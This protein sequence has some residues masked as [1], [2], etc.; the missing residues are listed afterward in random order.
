MYCTFNRGKPDGCRQRNSKISSRT[1]GC[2]PPH[3]AS[4]FVLLFRIAAHTAIRPPD[5]VSR[6]P[7]VRADGR[8]MVLLRRVSLSVAQAL[9]SQ[10]TNMRKGLEH[11]IR[12]ATEADGRASAAAPPKKRA[13]A[14]ECPAAGA[15][16]LDGAHTEKP[17]SAHK[18]RRLA[19]QKP[20]GCEISAAGC[21]ERGDER[22][23]ALE[24]QI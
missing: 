15:L 21:W 4:V 24:W 11:A 8:G 12:L 7:P 2:P 10:K 20:A 13:A 18:R 1:S 5:P 16:S 22:A 3:R 6:K 23:E 17:R 9:R 19:Q 14:V